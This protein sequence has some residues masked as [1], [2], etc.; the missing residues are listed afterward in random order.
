MEVIVMLQSL[1]DN[2]VDKGGRRF[3]FILLLLVLHAVKLRP[4]RE[5]IEFKLLE[6]R[7]HFSFYETLTIFK[8]FV[9]P[10][11]FIIQFGLNFCLI[12]EAGNYH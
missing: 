7:R 10:T 5:G 8:G 6:F 11:Q 1:S 9:I 12:F 2:L 4:E 3:A